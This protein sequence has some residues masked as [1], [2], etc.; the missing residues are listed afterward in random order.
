MQAR[1]MRPPRLPG[2]HLMQ[3]PDDRPPRRRPQRHA[4]PE[5]VDRH[6]VG[7]GG[8]VEI[9]QHACGQRSKGVVA[10]RAYAGA[11]ATTAGPIQGCQPCLQRCQSIRP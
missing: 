2:H 11:D 7:R 5:G 3:T 4:Q 9:V 10:S 1:P 8:R 6:R